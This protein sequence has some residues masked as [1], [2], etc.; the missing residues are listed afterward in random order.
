MNIVTRDRNSEMANRSKSKIERLIEENCTKNKASFSR[1]VISK[2]IEESRD[3]PTKKRSLD[4]E[5]VY[6]AQDYNNNG[7]H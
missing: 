2:V 6:T 7:L 5:E 4:D 1:K 3:E